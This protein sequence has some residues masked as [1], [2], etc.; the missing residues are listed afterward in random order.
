MYQFTEFLMSSMTP[1]EYAKALPLPSFATMCK[2]Y[3]LRHVEAF[4]LCRPIAREA[5]LSR[6]R[7][8]ENKME[9]WDP[10][11]EQNAKL[12]RELMTSDIHLSPDLYATFWTLSIVDV[13]FPEAQYKEA[14]QNLR[15]EI[16][17]KTNL[18]PS[19]KSRSE[20]RECTKAISKSENS[21]K[22]LR[23]EMKA[24]R[25]CF[26]VVRK[27]LENMKFGDFDSQSFLQTCLLP[28][29]LYDAASA[30]YVVVEREAR[31]YHFSYSLTQ[32]TRSC[33]VHNQ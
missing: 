27:G 12:M 33:H 20:I 32:K 31:E 8:E 25:S 19:L 17:K 21:L 24:Q 30:L 5:L 9:K 29:L 6:W 11:S 13:S 14:I 23:E 15:K 18:K 10:L 3:R 4:H 26:S 28:R 7:G 1:S 22:Q 2:K 16:E